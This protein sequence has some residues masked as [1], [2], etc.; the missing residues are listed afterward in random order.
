MRAEVDGGVALMDASPDEISLVTLVAAGADG[1]V[2]LEAGP[3]DGR[4]TAHQSR[5]LGWS[6]VSPT[7][8]PLNHWRPARD[9]SSVASRGP[10]DPAA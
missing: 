4:R 5:V 2:H 10:Q 3:I 7:T 6:G 1:L 8:A 9:T